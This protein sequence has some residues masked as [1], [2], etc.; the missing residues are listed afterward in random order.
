M[1]AELIRTFRFE[2]AHA[3]PN[4]P[5]EHKCRRLHGHSYR[6]DIHVTGPIDPEKGWVMDFGDVK[7]A[8][9]PVL[10][11]LD[12]RMLSDVPGLENSTSE[13][14]AKY[15]WARLRPALPLLSAVAVWESENS[16]CVYRGG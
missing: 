13:M 10:A 14:I 1:Q 8:V 12:H 4:V 16:R 11:E 15:L 6:V 3:L 2:A 5:A 9:E 7:R